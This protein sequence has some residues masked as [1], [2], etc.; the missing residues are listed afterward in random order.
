MSNPIQ[1][2]Q[3]YVNEAMGKLAL[4]IYQLS[5]SLTNYLHDQDLQLQDMVGRIGVLRVCRIVLSLC[6][7][8]WGGWG[9][10]HFSATSARSALLPR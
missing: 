5:V 9:G 1:T 8:L 10:V 2:T 4:T 6:V 7:Y 3:S